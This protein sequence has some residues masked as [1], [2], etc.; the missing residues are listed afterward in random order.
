ME[1]DFE[2]WFL[3][4]G[5]YIHPNVE[6][7]SDP[8]AGRYLRVV[9]GQSLEADSLIVSCPH[10]L[11]ISWLNVV[12]GS[13]TFLGQFAL[14][15]AYDTVNQVVV[16]RFFLINEY[17]KRR[18]SFWWP[19]IRSLLQPTEAESLGTPMYYEENDWAWIRGTNLECAARK[20]ESM[21]H[22]EYD[23]AMQ[24]L[25]PMDGSHANKWSWPLYKWAATIMSSRCFPASALAN[26]VSMKR[27]PGSA[28][29]KP[30]DAL[31]PGSPVL[32]PGNDLLNHRPSAKVTWQWTSISC[33][34]VTNELLASGAQMCNNYGQKSN[35]ECKLRL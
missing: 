21:W 4:N 33:R 13:E 8:V 7:A 17:L 20:T 12:K 22:L 5:G 31:E 3:A 23:E 28:D 24:S 11:T 35:E 29:S 6:I 15:E 10:E 30:D 25:V 14:G 34:L 19:Y 26:N 2:Q 27:A 32:I 16:V 1:D 18:E 9:D